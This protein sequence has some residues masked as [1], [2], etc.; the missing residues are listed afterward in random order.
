MIVAAA[1][2]DAPNAARHGIAH[3]RRL[4]ADPF[5]VEVYGREHAERGALS[6]FDV[7]FMCGG[8]PRSLLR[9]L[10]DS[11]LWDEALER[12]RGGATLAG[13]SAGAMVLCG[14]C[15]L[16]DP[17]ARVPTRWTRGLGPLDDLGLAVHADERPREWL[18]QIASTAPCP[19]VA[20]ETDTG[21][22][23]RAGADPV[24]AGPRRI[25]GL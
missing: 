7:L 21:L 8:S 15:T 19:V 11:P 17:G 22:I 6:D 4:G 5:L 14:H 3:Y 16:P 24:V 2:A 23:L 1:G 18:T 13:S 20:M 10:L 25:Y 12:W 9:A